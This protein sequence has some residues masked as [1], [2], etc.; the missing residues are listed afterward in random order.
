MAGTLPVAMIDII[1]V[2]KDLPVP[3]VGASKAISG[4]VFM[5]RRT[6]AVN[7]AAIATLREALVINGKPP[8]GDKIFCSAA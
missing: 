1:S 2:N 6:K 5:L 3:A 4:A 8:K 7:S